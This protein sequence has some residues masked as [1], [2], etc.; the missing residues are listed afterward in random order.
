MI[1]DDSRRGTATS[2]GGIFA[3]THWSVVLAASESSSAQASHALEQLCRAYWYPLYVYVRRRGYSAADAEDLTQEFFTRLLHH[4]SIAGAQQTKGRFRCFLLGALKHL[5]ADETARARAKKRGGDRFI[6][7]W[8]QDGAE[9]RFA[10]EPA[11]GSSPERLFERRWAL[12]VLNHAAARLRAEFT[13]V[14]DAPLFEHLKAYVTGEATAPTYATTAN[15]LGLSESAV[16]SAIYR[17]RRR[18]GELVRAEVAQTVSDAN[19]LEAEIRH[20]RLVFSVR[21]ESFSSGFLST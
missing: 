15:Q 19:E 12:T 16:K 14:G 11:D 9:Q 6:L 3:T 5:L 1:P 21:S 18:Y 8:E 20:L 10:Q 13:T 4:H 17:L 7:S 2:A